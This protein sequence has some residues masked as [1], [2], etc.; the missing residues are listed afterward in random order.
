VSPYDQRTAIAKACGWDEGGRNNRS[1]NISGTNT[2]IFPVDY[3]NDLNAMHEAEK[4]LTPRQREI[5]ADI[6]DGQSSL[7]QYTDTTYIGYIELPA[8][9]AFEL[10]HSSAAQR[11][12]AFLRTLQLWEEE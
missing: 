11:A 2:W 3:L 7:K 6:L 5:F 1:Y 8:S 9:A 12:E 10:V 4:I